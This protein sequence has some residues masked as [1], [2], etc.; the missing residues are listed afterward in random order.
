MDQQAVVSLIGQLGA[1]GA[2]ALIVWRALA[3]HAIRVEGF[4][5]T[6]VRELTM[7]RAEVRT[8]IEVLSD[9]RVGRRIRTAPQGYPAVPVGGFRHTRDTSIDGD[10]DAG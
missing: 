9:G 3:A 5:E 6:Q 10:P 8:L 1:V 4:M 2:L 7:L